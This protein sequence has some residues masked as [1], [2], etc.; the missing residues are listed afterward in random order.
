MRRLAVVALALALTACATASGKTIAELAV[1]LASGPLAGDFGAG[2]DEAARGLAART[3]YRA[4]EGGLAGAP[5][6]WKIS[7]TLF[8]TVT[9]QQA[10]S[11]GSTNCR[12]YTHVIVQNAVTRSAAATACRD[13]AGIWRPLS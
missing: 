3:E 10:F 4:L 13:D 11:V 9:P 7:T 6:N 8:G 5:V 12:R 1:P 2:L